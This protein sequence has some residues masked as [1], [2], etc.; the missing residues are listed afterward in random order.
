MEFFFSGNKIQRTNMITQPDATF[1]PIG[2]L[3]PEE[4]KLKGFKWQIKRRPTL[5]SISKY[6]LKK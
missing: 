4:L 2:E 1:Y 5:T 3:K 6:F